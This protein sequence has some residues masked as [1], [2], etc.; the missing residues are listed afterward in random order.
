[1]GDSV[2]SSLPLPHVPA[3][4]AHADSEGL[5]DT[6]VL[7]GAPRTEYICPYG[8]GTLQVA[9]LQITGHQE[10]DWHKHDDMWKELIAIEESE[11]KQCLLE[12]P[13]KKKNRKRRSPVVRFLVG[14]WGTGLLILLAVLC[15]SAIGVFTYYYSMY[16]RLVDAKLEAGL[17]SNN[18]MLFAAPRPILLGEAIAPEDI[19]EYLRHCGYSESNSDRLGWYHLRPDAIEI[20][21]GPD[22]H[23]HEGAVIKVAHGKVSEI[24]SLS[25]NTQRN[26]SISSRS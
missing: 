7:L 25:D 13:P 4:A 20:N 10:P 22:A 23:D 26:E 11:S 9:E 24:I 14:P 19:A 16:S 6:H 5:L 18:S 8:H 3:A 1:M 17:F 2:G 15:V 12:V 21:P